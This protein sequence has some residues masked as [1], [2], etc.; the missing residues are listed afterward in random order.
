MATVSSCLSPN[1]GGSLAR[2]AGVESFV[3]LDLELT[4][5]AGDQQRIIEIAAARFRDGQVADAFCSLVDPRCGLTPRIEVLTGICQAEVDAAPHLEE[6]LPRFLSFVGSDL[7]VGQSI[8]LDH[9][10]LASAGVYLSNPLLDTFELAS[11]LLPGLPSY[12]L[13]TIARSLGVAVEQE[14]RALGDALV[15]GRVFLALADRAAQLTIPVL[16]QIN[17]LAAQLQDWPFA[18]LFREARRRRVRDHFT[19]PSALSTQNPE[20]RT[21]NSALS[22]QHPA[23]G[24]QPSALDA[25]ELTLFTQPSRSAPRSSLQPAPSPIPVDAGELRALLVPGGTVASALSG[26]EEREEQVRMMETVAEAMNGGEHLMVEAG[27]GTG[28]SMAYLLPAIYY[29]V[30]NGR[31]VVISTNTLNLQDQLYQK[32]IPALQACLP[33]AFRTAI[34]KGRANYLCLRRWLVLSR[35]P[36]LSPAETQLLIKTLIWLSTTESGDRSEL[37]LSPR[38][39]DLWSRISAQVES[40][41]LSNCPQF[42]RGNCFVLRARRNAE[43]AHL[44]VVNHALLLSDLAASGGVLPEYSHLVVDE[45][46][47][48]EEEA[49][50]QL[51]FTLSW[52]DLHS[53]LAALHQVTSGQRVVGF[54]PELLGS[55]RSRSAPPQTVAALRA[56]VSTATSAVEAAIEEGRG[57]FETLS[58]FVHDHAE[59][60]SRPGA[61]LRITSSLRTQPGWSEVEVRWAELASRLESLGRQLRRLEVTIEGLEGGQ[62]LE[63]EGSIAELS[64]LQSYLARLCSQGDDIVSTPSP[65]G[66]YWIAGGIA[67]ED[68]TLSSAPL[69]VGE[70][71]NAALFSKKESVV[72]TSATLTTEGGFDYVKERLGLEN[73][74]ELIVG[75]PFDY[76]RSTL[77]YV[78][79]DIPEPTR[80]SCQRA[81]E[82]AITD[83]VLTLEGRTLVLFTSHAQ[84]RTTSSAIRPRLE[85]QGILVLAHGLDG[86]RRRLLQ[87]FKTSPRAVLMGTSSFWEGIDVVGQALS[88]LVIVKLPFSVPTDPI[89]AARSEAFEEPFRQYSVPQTILRLKQGFG[90]LIRSRSDRGVVV[91]LDSRVGSKFYGPAFIHSLPQCTVRMGPAAHVAEAAE[92]WLEAVE[93]RTSD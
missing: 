31:R 84:L 38:E 72:L 20:L 76:Q 58:C 91:I 23:P 45:A 59:E 43:G 41:A 35:S 49:T 40:C 85:E 77:L 24:V 7:L 54:L 82:T 78:V 60:R 73:P 68:L 75:S 15:A 8:E 37:N 63:Q 10:C 36:N 56:L 83:L 32:D 51:G 30:R 2:I 22:T 42:R 90:R 64:G 93:T 86:S 17:Q 12:D 13:S 5:F 50:Q 74:R 44:L 6:V 81:V 52:G 69:H 92:G 21:Q 39:S 25:D 57:F 88:C 26:Y 66:I 3:A 4:P 71:L 89:F 65:N 62:M 34:L 48:L 67:L 19:R 33:V 87:A 18:D 9:E 29:S 61:R 47:R 14:H 27:T 28:K 79:K 1:G 53:F 70:T 80:P 55:L 11:L 46:H 16:A